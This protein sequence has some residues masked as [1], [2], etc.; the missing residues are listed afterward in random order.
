MYAFAPQ[1]TYFVSDVLMNEFFF[2]SMFEYERLQ[3]EK[4]EVCQNQDVTVLIADHSPLLDF[5]RITQL[6]NIR[7]K[8]P[9]FH[10]STIYGCGQD[11]MYVCSPIILQLAKSAFSDL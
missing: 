9:R 8:C 4:V 1:N 7:S 10:V 3:K 2:S 5:R 11:A 6:K